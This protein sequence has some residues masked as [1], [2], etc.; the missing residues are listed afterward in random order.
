MGGDTGCVVRVSGHLGS[1]KGDFSANATVYFGRE[2]GLEGRGA[3]EQEAVLTMSVVFIAGSSMICLFRRNALIILRARAR[4]IRFHV[5]PDS[6]N[7]T[8]WIQLG[9][10][11]LS[12]KGAAT[13]VV[14]EPSR[15]WT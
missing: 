8:V 12:L 1:V 6:P 5:S 14:L 3:E 10:R 2:G 15:S 7:L 4:L 13:W 11:Y 9:R